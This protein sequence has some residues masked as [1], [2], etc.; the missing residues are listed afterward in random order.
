MGEEV[1]EEVV[2]ES[3]VASGLKGFVHVSCVACMCSRPLAQADNQVTLPPHTH[4][5]TPLNTRM[6]AHAERE[7]DERDCATDT[8]RQSLSRSLSNFLPPASRLSNDLPT[9]VLVS[10]FVRISTQASP[11]LCKIPNPCDYKLQGGKAV[12]PRSFILALLLTP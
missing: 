2:A 1:G 11:P 4:A 6:C 3:P 9:A 12:K 8:D 10:L 5:R 7:T